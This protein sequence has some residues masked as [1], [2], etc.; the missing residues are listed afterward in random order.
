MTTEEKLREVLLPV[1]N[2]K[3][4]EQIQPGHSLIGDLGADSL[5]FVE[6]IHLIDRNFGIE[7]SAN[8]ILLGGQKLNME[9]M[10]QDNVLTE[11]GARVLQSTFAAREDNIRPGMNKI[12]LFTLLTVHDLALIIESRLAKA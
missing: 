2:L 1:F 11:S 6:I 3:S 9:D 8:E 7:M 5:D 10:F 4:A 12:E